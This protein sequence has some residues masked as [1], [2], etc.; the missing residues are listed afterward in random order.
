[1]AKLYTLLFIFL[2]AIVSSTGYLYL[3]EKVIAGKIKIANGQ[4]Q[5]AD[6]QAMLAKGKVKLQNGKQ[7]LSGAKNLYD[8]FHSIPLV[9]VVNKIPIA[10]NILDIGKSN[11]EEGNSL[12]AKGNEKIKAGEKQLADGKA[13]LQRGMNK[14]NRAN[15]IRTACGASAIIFILLLIIFGYSWR[16][17]LSKTFKHRIRK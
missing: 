11:I 16:S 12:V 2:L 13:D 6:G 14:L 4:Q 8:G 1:M 7:R 15:S 3:T 10:G 5:L 17:E 9:N